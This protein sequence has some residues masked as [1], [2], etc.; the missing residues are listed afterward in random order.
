[1][2]LYRILVVKLVSSMMATNLQKTFN[3][4]EV[5]GRSLVCRD[6][7]NGEEENFIPD[8]SVTSGNRNSDVHNYNRY[9]QHLIIFF[10]FFDIS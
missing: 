9:R 7:K 10:F 3:G 4:M 8:L 1:M 6:L 2:I 5:N